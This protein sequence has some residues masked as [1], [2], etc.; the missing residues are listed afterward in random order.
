MGTENIFY[1]NYMNND[2]TPFEEK[3]SCSPNIQISHLP[4]N[5]P[6]LPP[7]PPPQKKNKKTKTKKKNSKYPSPPPSRLSYMSTQSISISDTYNYYT[8]YYYNWVIDTTLQQ[9]QFQTMIFLSWGTGRADPDCY[10]ASYVLFP[11]FLPMLA[12]LSPSD[13]IPEIMFTLT[14]KVCS[15][16]TASK[17]RLWNAL[18]SL[19]LYLSNGVYHYQLPW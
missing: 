17:H 13:K 12:T 1:W 9:L 6:L 11:T 7:S 19:G 3:F 10:T 16:Q 15:L 18:T 8:M 2:I 14:Q 5:I 4:Q